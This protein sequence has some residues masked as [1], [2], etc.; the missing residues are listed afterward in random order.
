MFL[1]LGSPFIPY[2]CE[3]GVRING[4]KTSNVICNKIPQT[5]DASPTLGQVVSSD[6]VDQLE[7]DTQT[8][9][10]LTTA[11]TT[12]MSPT[13]QITH[14]NAKVR[15]SSPSSTAESFGKAHPAVPLPHNNKN[16]Q[17]KH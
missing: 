14:P 4:T 5:A 15:P 6:T 13:M 17:I 1:T 9:G 7:E 16:T 8:W 10:L 12:I 2:R 11:A 3:F